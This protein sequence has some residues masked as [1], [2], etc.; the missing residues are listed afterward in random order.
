MLK[1][2]VMVWIQVYLLG[3]KLDGGNRLIIEA[4]MGYS[5]ADRATGSGAQNQQERHVVPAQLADNRTSSTA[6]LQMQGMMH[7]HP[8]SIAQRKMQA[9]VQ[10]SLVTQKHAMQDVQGTGL[11]QGKFSPSSQGA[12]IQCYTLGTGTTRS[13][14][15]KGTG[16]KQR[17][18][19][20]CTYNY[21]D[22]KK[23]DAK[24]AGTPTANPA[25]WATWLVNKKGG[26]NATQLHVVNKRWGGLGG[27]DDKNIVPGSPAEN[28][29]HLHEAEKKFDEICFNNT[30]TA[31]KDAK[32][33][34]TATPK[35]STAEDV[36]GGAK[37]FGD[38]TLSVKI[39][40]GAGSETFPV[41]DGSEGLVIQEGD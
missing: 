14:T 10:S 17:T 19:E 8:Q 27:K 21:V 38:P 26:R 5:N 9:S 37:N 13:V 2:G 33:E 34:C 16:T 11:L 32:Y 24:Q 15:L 1:H 35:Y 31:V 41:T 30:G 22:Y 29:H 4:Y 6:Q 39:T 25:A 20:E 23:G 3:F 28:S 7:A 12:T 18:F 40:T 36:S